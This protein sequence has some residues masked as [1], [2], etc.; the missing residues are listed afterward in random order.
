MRSADSDSE[1][2]PLL[3]S[4]RLN[5]DVP[6]LLQGGSFQL[7]TRGAVAPPPPAPAATPWIGRDLGGYRILELIGAG[8]F[9]MV[10]VAR[11]SGT[12]DLVAV[13][14]PRAA[15]FVDHLKREALISARFQ[16]PDVPGI[17]EV[18]LDHDPPFL[19]MPFVAGTNLPLPAAA[20]RPREIVEAFRIFRGI[21]AVVA[22]LHDAQ[23]AHG[24]LKP[25]NI[26]LDAVGRCRLMDLG[27]A[28]Q[29][30]AARQLSTLRASVVS[31]T[32]ERIEGTLEFMAPE[33]T[34]GEE[35][36]RAADVYALG[37]ILHHLL[38]GRPPSFG[39]S[40][41]Q[42][43][44]YLPS[45]TAAL[46]REMLRHDVSARLGSAG[47]VIPRVDRLIAAEER[48]LRRRNGHE[49]RRVFESRMKTLA[50]GARLM[51]FVLAA[52]GALVWSV[53]IVPALS[54]I[55]ISDDG[56]DV[57]VA[58][59][60]AAGYLLGWLSIVLGVTTINAWVLGVPERDYKN[61]RGHP[62]W[63]FMMQ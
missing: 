5:L 42:L 52:A 12:E 57:L 21:A 44:P 23:I 20:P 30:V 9:S 53:K 47:E 48:C 40:P 11:R 37:V 43:N 7:D 4:R 63:N 58:L 6:A 17:L 36:G 56:F 31:I 54:G 46:L 32:G 62:W 33:V 49:R 13:K 15:G 45:G 35:P 22:R 3:H 51:L 1:R 28:R 18:K 25:G 2:D 59:S 10:F 29:Q 38:C 55:T 61:R 14:L 19:V 41:A 8:G 50:R 27:L 26:R 24:D 34:A 39:V 16:D 60:C